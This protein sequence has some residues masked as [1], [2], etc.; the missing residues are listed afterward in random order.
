M[1]NEQRNDSIDINSNELGL[2]ENV[3]SFE[4]AK[5]VMQEISPARTEFLKKANLESIYMF[6]LMGTGGVGLASVLIGGIPAGVLI[7]AAIAP[8]AITSIKAA[9]NIIKNKKKNESI[10]SGDYFE[11]K[12]EKEIIREANEDYIREANNGKVFDQIMNPQKESE[13]ENG[14]SR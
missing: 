8:F 10:M 7:P 12:S 6:G 13:L 11:G 3:S 4:E 9:C 5:K 1:E 14:R 2:R